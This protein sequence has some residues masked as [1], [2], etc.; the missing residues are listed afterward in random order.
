MRRGDEKNGI[1]VHVKK[2]QHDTN[3]VEEVLKSE[4]QYWR[5]IVEVVNIQS[6]INIM[7]L[8]GNSSGTS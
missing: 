2:T 1:A 3:W 5:R 4:T 7:K 6:Q 8:S